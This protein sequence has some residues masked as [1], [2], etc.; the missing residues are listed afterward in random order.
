MPKG[1]SAA[2]CSWLQG[3]TQDH[4]GAHAVRPFDEYEVGGTRTETPCLFGYGRI[5]RVLVNDRSARKIVGFKA[6]PKL[7]D[8]PNALPRVVPRS[9]PELA[10]VRFD[11]TRHRDPNTGE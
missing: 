6:P 1:T 11:G 2:T 10:G 3:P 9:R 8:G 5:V 7:L 4:A